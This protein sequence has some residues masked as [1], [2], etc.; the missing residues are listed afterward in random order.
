MLQ[1]IARMIG[2]F[3]VAKIEGS[4]LRQMGHLTHHLVVD[5]TAPHK[6][7]M[8]QSYQISDELLPPLH[9]DCLTLHNNQSLQSFHI[10]NIIAPE[11]VLPASV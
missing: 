1:M 5:P 8:P 10:P 3:S 7:D 2:Y 4:Q 6:I 11:I 9:I